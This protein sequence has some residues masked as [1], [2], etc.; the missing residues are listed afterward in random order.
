MKEIKNKKLIIALIA[1][2]P[3]VGVGSFFA[4]KVLA[5][6][7]V[8]KT[9]SER[10]SE[11]LSLPED[12]VQNALSDIQTERRKERMDDKLSQAVKDGII[13]EDQ[14]N[15]LIEKQTEMHKKMSEARSE[16]EQWAKDNNIDLQKLHGNNAMG[17]GKMG[18]GF[19]GGMM[20]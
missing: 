14:K 12:T 6:N 15:K 7:T 20:R 19:H 8:P 11:K 16:F 17:M 5:E 10:L 1:L 13:T 4:S 3:L 18:R 2:A 9:M